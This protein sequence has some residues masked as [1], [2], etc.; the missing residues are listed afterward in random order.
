MNFFAEV[1]HLVDGLFG[2]LVGEL[3]LDSA[4]CCSLLQVY[5]NF[6]QVSTIEQILQ[7]K[8]QILLAY[9]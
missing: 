8:H 2:G 9:L 3:G 6:L 1:E 7:S 5:R 4:G